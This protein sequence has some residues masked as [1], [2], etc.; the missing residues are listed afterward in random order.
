[1]GR[2]RYRRSRYY[3]HVPKYVKEELKEVRELI[4]QILGVQRPLEKA[5]P[6]SYVDSTFSD[7]IA[8]VDIPKCFRVPYMKHYDGSTDP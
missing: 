3:E 4:K 1:M 2:P 5:T 6:A 8:L 7:H